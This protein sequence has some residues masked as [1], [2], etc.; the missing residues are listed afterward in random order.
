MAFLLLCTSWVFCFPVFPLIHFITFLPRTESN[1][2]L[3]FL[4]AMA[5]FS[6]F[7]VTPAIPNAYRPDV[8]RLIDSLVKP[9]SHLVV[10]DAGFEAEAVH[11]IDHQLWCERRMEMFVTVSRFISEAVSLG[12]SEVSIMVLLFT[13]IVA[14]Y[15]IGC[16]LISLAILVINRSAG[17][18]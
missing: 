4:Q 9:R 5:G 15:L 17:C 3:V 14:Y 8:I 13:T 12:Q 6:D 11:H 7:R 16:L 10:M 18:S 1:T 2:S